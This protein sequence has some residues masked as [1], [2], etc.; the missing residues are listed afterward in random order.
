VIDVNDVKMLR[1]LREA[2]KPTLQ[3][4]AVKAGLAAQ[5]CWSAMRGDVSGDRVERIRRVPVKAV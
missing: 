3:Q 4:V 2:S 1:R 5:T